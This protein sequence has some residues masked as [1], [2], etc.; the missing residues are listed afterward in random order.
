[1]LEIFKVNVTTLR[2]TVD[3]FLRAKRADYFYFHF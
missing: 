1:V 2:T 3:F